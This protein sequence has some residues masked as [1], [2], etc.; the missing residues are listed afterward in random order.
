MNSKE[1]FE[2]KLRVKDKDGKIINLE[3]KRVELEVDWGKKR[4]KL[5]AEVIFNQ[6]GKEYRIIITELKIWKSWLKK[7]SS[8]FNWKVP[9]N[10]SY[11]IYHDKPSSDGKPKETINEEEA[12]YYIKFANPWREE[13]VTFFLIMIIAIVVFILIIFSWSWGKRRRNKNN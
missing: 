12:D 1:I 11:E 13:I 3:N 6:D 7:R 4:V 10:S 8:S 9:P 2:I 5:P